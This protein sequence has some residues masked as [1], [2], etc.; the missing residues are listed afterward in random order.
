MFG[1][2]GTGVKKDTLLRIQSLEDTLDRMLSMVKHHFL[3]KILTG[4]SLKST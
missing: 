4:F 2:K 1:V 3:M